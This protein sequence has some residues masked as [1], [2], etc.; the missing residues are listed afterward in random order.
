MVD[1][2]KL[3]KRLSPSLLLYKK[4]SIIVF[5]LLENKRP[6]CV[7]INRTIAILQRPDAVSSTIHAH[8]RASRLSR[9]E[10]EQT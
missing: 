10:L 9:G 6:I 1:K 3:L 8:K 4:Y 5:D 7:Q 2:N